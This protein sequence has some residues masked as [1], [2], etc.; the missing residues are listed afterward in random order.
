MRKICFLDIILNNNIELYVKGDQ[1]YT[2]GLYFIMRFA[3]CRYICIYNLTYIT[4]NTYR[5]IY[6]F[7]TCEISDLIRL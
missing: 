4:R 6:Y 1:A 2:P 3:L 5:Y 7:V